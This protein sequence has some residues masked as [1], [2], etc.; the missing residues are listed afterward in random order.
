MRK[1]PIL[2]WFIRHLQAFEESLDAEQRAAL[3]AEL[4]KHPEW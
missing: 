1:I 4:L 3:A 2:A